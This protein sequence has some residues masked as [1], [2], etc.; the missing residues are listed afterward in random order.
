MSKPDDV[1]TKHFSISVPNDSP[2]RAP[3]CDPSECPQA[4]S[5][6]WHWPTG[7]AVSGPPTARSPEEKKLI[8]FSSMVSDTSS[9]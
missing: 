9:S 8:K 2:L 7:G 5:K 3:G 6:A 4:E 1:K